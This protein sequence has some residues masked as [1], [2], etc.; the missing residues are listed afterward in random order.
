MK[1]ILFRITCVVFLMN[2]VFAVNYSGG[3][4]DIGLGEGTELQL[5]FHAHEDAVI[6]GAVLG[7]ETGRRFGS[8]T[9]EYFA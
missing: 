4:A 2:T 6:D 8:N 5:H 1:S 3:H 7:S 9:V